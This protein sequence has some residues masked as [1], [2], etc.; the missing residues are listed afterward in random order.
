MYKFVLQCGMKSEKSL[1]G[2][3]G[4]SCNMSF[5]S[6]QKRA[7]VMTLTLHMHDWIAEENQGDS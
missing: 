7:R 2:E 6:N 4:D 1:I 5:I 3:T